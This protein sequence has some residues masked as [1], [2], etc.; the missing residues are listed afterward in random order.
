MISEIRPN[1]SRS[2]YMTILANLWLGFSKKEEKK[3]GIHIFF[4]MI[5]PLVDRPYLLANLNMG[6]HLA[7]SRDSEL[8][9][10]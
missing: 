1:F 10:S 3:H 4:V 6:C 8:Y 2:G 7:F 9:I 5:C